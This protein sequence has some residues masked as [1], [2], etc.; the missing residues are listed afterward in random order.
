MK[1]AEAKSLK[2]AGVFVFFALGFS[3]SYW[4]LVSLSRRGALPFEMENSFYG[5]VL[6]AVLRDFGPA[7]TALI[8][9]AL[10]Q[11]RAG[12]KD[13]WR[14]LSRWRVSWQLYSLAILGPLVLAGLVALVA[15]L[16]GTMNRN[17]HSGSPLRLIVIFFLMAIFDGP[18]GEEIG[19][20]GLLLPQ[21]LKSFGPITASIV[22][23]GVWW[24]WHIPLYVADGKPLTTGDWAEFLAETVGLSLIMTWFFLKSGGSTLMTIVLHNASNYSILLVLLSVWR[25]VGGSKFPDYAHATL[26]VLVALLTAASLWHQ[27]QISKQR[28]IREATHVS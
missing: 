27:S 1:P 10:Y 26:V 17:P 24:A 25:A 4:L 15:V 16:T 23:G 22:V 13:I 18:L 7:I 6:K 19:W 2:V 8:V 5:V 9:A 28:L 3:F 14:S 21:L 12:L 20:R 11:G